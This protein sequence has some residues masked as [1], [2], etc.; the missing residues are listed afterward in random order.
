MCYRLLW[1][2]YS[3]LLISK[4]YCAVC[5]NPVVLL[6]G[7][8]NCLASRGLQPAPLLSWPCSPA[9]KQVDVSIVNRSPDHWEIACSN[10][11]D[12]TAIYSREL[13]RAK[14]A[15]GGLLSLRPLSCSHISN[16]G[17]TSAS[18]RIRRDADSA[19]VKCVTLPPCVA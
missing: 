6:W 2:L 15:C 8:V 13:R 18:S 12:A 16:H 1:Q 11:G 14:V 7:G 17:N 10:P 5:L 19:V 9:A 3:F 4:L